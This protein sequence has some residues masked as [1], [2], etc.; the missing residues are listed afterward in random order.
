MKKSSGN[1]VVFQE[2]VLKLSYKIV[3]SIAIDYSTKIW[4]H[5]VISR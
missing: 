3:R 1:R 4:Y 2:N 5:L